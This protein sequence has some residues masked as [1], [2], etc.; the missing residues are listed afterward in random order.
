[1][2]V[3]LGVLVV[4]IIHDVDAEDRSLSRADFHQEREQL[5]NFRRSE[6]VE[7]SDVS[8]GGD[9]DLSNNWIRHVLMG[10]KV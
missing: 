1:M 8:F 10:V 6:V 3:M 7:V 5:V 2:K 4:E 9:D